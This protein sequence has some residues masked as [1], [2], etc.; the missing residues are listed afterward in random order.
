MVY[1]VPPAALCYRPA[2]ED[3]PWADA[4]SMI[5]RAACSMRPEYHVP[6]ALHLAYERRVSTLPQRFQLNPPLWRATRLKPG[7]GPGPRP[8][9]LLQSHAWCV[10]AVSDEDRWCSVLEPRQFWL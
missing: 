6:S 1:P 9:A 8:Q 7:T 5:S 10:R 4:P 2:R 3:L